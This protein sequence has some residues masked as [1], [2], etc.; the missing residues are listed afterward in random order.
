MCIIRKR[1][2]NNIMNLTRLRHIMR[3]NNIV[4]IYGQYN[5]RHNMVR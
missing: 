4:V 1:R 2:H 5:T 3:H